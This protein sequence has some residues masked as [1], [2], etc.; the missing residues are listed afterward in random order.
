[1][2]MSRSSSS[3]VNLQQ[4]ENNIDNDL[5]KQV[6]LLSKLII[7]TLVAMVVMIISF[8]MII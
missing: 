4:D 2:K 5:D 8:I 6:G 3:D 7:G 1:M